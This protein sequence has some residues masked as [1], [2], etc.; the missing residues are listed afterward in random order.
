MSRLVPVRN[1]GR[2]EGANPAVLQRRTVFPASITH[3][4]EKWKSTELTVRG[5]G[6]RADAWEAGLGPFQLLLP[7]AGATDLGGWG[8]GNKRP[9]VRSLEV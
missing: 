3:A 8:G 1:R 6:S 5:P 2:R 4:P 9:S 7:P